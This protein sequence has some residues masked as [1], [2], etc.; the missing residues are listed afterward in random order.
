MFDQFNQ[1]NLGEHYSPL[2]ITSWGDQHNNTADNNS[3]AA[4]HS[5]ADSN[6]QVKA[7]GIGLGNLHRKGS[8]FKPVAEEAIL[9]QRLKQLT[10]KDKA[11][12]NTQ[13]PKPRNV[14]TT[15][16][17]PNRQ[18]AGGWGAGKLSSVPF[19]EQSSTSPPLDEQQTPLATHSSTPTTTST[20]TAFTPPLTT[21]TLLP[22]VQQPLIHFNI[23]LAE[24]INMSFI[25][26]KGD[27][28]ATA[29][30]N[31]IANHH[32]HVSSEARDGI[33]RTVTMIYEAKLNSIRKD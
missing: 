33:V 13:Q 2:N 3:I 15:A 21:S 23:K 5:I 26:R 1:S 22:P 8:N 31:F 10:T 20:T 30:D 9:Q 4:W 17:P 11:T 18:A 12:K 32:L 7:G 27:D 6:T 29:T 24:G 14:P 28:I 19:W 16:R 25:I